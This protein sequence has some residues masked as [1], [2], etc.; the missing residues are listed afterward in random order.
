[1]DRLHNQRKSIGDYWN[2]ANVREFI[3]RNKM[4][5]M[6]HFKS[7]NGW[8]MFMGTGRKVDGRRTQGRKKDDDVISWVDQNDC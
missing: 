6:A 8:R 1:M 4:I 5:F 2:S 7:F 3:K